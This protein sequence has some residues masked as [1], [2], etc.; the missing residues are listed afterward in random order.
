MIRMHGAA[1]SNVERVSTTAGY[2]PA[3]N[4][5]QALLEPLPC[6]ETRTSST[7]TITSYCCEFAGYDVPQ[8]NSALLL[9]DR[10]SLLKPS[11][12]TCFSQPPIARDDGLC[13]Q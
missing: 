4:P 1:S 11:R 6:A 2:L 13:L 10:V 8:N 5:W 3:A 7:R 9:C 12:V